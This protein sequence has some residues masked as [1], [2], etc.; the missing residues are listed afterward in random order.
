MKR[1]ESFPLINTKNSMY[2]NESLY[3]NESSINFANLKRTMKLTRMQKS[4][5]TQD[6]FL[7]QKS[8]RST[9]PQSPS[10]SSL[11]NGKFML[12][13]NIEY[14]KNKNNF[15]LEEKLYKLDYLNKFKKIKTNLYK[16]KFYNSSDYKR[17]EI[18]KKNDENE[19]SEEDKKDDID[20]KD[21]E[22][23]KDN[24]EN[25]NN[26][27]EEEEKE[28]IIDFTQ[29]FWGSE[30]NLKNHENYD[31]GDEDNMEN[32]EEI[33][34]DSNNPN[35]INYMPDSNDLETNKET[36]GYN[37]NRMSLYL[38]EMQSSNNN[39]VNFNTIFQNNTIKNKETKKHYDFKK[40]KI[41]GKKKIEKNPFNFT[42]YSS[43]DNIGRFHKLYRS[44][45]NLCRK[46]YINEKNASYAFIKACDREKVICN[47]LGLLKRK[48]D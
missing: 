38:T 16:K 47:P 8:Q 48:G 35:I 46:H 1:D 29:N 4:N 10:T 25:K 42:K 40:I 45:K 9:I 32:E 37:S 44:F 2:H 30:I 12:E 43:L 31:L 15:L 21:D 7:T 17:K 39:D 28:N 41:V 27:E 26:E 34:T 6:L 11:F 20:N 33:E 5:S 23:K 19:K 3:T 24:K 13:K 36:S 14:E 22:D 18:E